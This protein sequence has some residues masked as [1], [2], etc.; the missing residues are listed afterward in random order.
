MTHEGTVING[1]I[2][3]DG[4]ARLP[5]GER[6][7]VEIMDAD[8]PAPPPQPYD[9]VKELAMLREALEDAKAGRTRPFEEVMAEIAARYHLPPLKGE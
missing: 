1:V 4:G 9:R 5:E 2:V 7:R 8:D 6:V 3:L